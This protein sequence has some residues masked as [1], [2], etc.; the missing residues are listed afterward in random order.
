MRV[1]ALAACILAHSVRV[2]QQCL[3]ACTKEGSS[4]SVASY[5]VAGDV[6]TTLS[7]N[8]FCSQVSTGL[9][10]FSSKSSVTYSVDNC[11]CYDCKKSTNGTVSECEEA[12]FTETRSSST[13]TAAPGS[14]SSASASET[15]S[16]STTTAVP[17]SNSAASASE[18]SSTSVHYL[19]LLLLAVVILVFIVTVAIRYRRFTATDQSAEDKADIESP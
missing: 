16:S 19:W 6:R 15:T 7:G 14:N 8:A 18:T 4:C 13:T 11:S 2:D 3:E 10:F 1:V 12:F 5:I 17:E 9:S